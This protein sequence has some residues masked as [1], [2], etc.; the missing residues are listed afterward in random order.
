[1]LWKLLGLQKVFD[2]LF[3]DAWISILLPSDLCY[4]YETSEKLLQE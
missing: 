1:M 2:S 3:D 4:D